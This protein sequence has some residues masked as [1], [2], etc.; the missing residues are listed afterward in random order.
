M[1]AFALYI[2][3]TSQRSYSLKVTPRE[4]TGDCLG[5]GRL[6][7]NAEHAG[8]IGSDDAGRS[9]P[10]SMSKRLAVTRGKIFPKIDMS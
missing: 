7:G 8:H 5:D 1:S 10:E 4:V 3:K 2:L 9:K 6:L